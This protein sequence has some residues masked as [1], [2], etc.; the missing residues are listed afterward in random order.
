MLTQ[1]AKGRDF[2]SQLH[3]TK[4]VDRNGVRCIMLYE[5][6]AARL[7]DCLATGKF[8]N[9]ASGAVTS[10]IVPRCRL[11]SSILTPLVFF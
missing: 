1:V 2:A 5:F 4:L 3:G 9:H 8:I 11:R 6:K 7:T 10:P